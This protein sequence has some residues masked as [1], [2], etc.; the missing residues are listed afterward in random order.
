MSLVFAVLNRHILLNRAHMLRVE[1]PLAERRRVLSRG[2]TGLIPYLVATALAVVSP[3]VTL[4]IC[5]AVAVFYALPVASGGSPA[6]VGSGLVAVSASA[7]AA[8]ELRAL[9]GKDSVLP[10]TTR[11][12][13][14]DYSETHNL[15][16]RA[17]AV[18]L[19]EGRRRRRRDG[20]LVRR[21]RR[22]DDPPRRRYRAGRRR[23]AA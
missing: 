20:A 18:A 3:Y 10:G 9:L 2:L 5:G 14:S 8:N 15:R 22:G 4:V 13:L 16:G 17:D 12:Y 11:E 21:P 23:G 19:P 7:S 6:G 1:L